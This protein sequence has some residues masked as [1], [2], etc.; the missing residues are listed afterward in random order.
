MDLHIK[1]VAPVFNKVTILTAGSVLLLP[2][3]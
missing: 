2:Q 3:K 1:K